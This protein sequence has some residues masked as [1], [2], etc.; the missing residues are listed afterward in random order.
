MK[1]AGADA[2][3]VVLLHSYANPSHEEQAAER[4]K[5]IFPGI[6]ARGVTLSIPMPGHGVSGR[7]EA[8]A[9][10]AAAELDALIQAGADG[11]D[12]HPPGRHI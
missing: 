4:L 10:A 8:A 9:R 1:R 2:S 3:A 6:D 5:Q 11:F 12:P 7:G